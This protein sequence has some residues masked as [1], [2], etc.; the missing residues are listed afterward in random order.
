MK[1]LKN[2]LSEK[3]KRIVLKTCVLTAPGILHTKSFKAML[4]LILFNI[5]LWPIADKSYS[6]SYGKRQPGTPT[7]YKESMI[8]DLNSKGVTDQSTK[9]LK[10]KQKKEKAQ[11]N[12][13]WRQ[14]LISLHKRLC[15][16]VTC[17][18][19]ALGLMTHIDFSRHLLS[20]T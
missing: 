6:K 1:L 4:D 7:D 15:N 17:F 20:L 8:Q 19:K 10:Q 9:L 14:N 2:E 16:A 13:F 11:P 18:T 5:Y 12:F 3:Q